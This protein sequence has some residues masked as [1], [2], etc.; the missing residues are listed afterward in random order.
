MNYIMIENLLFSIPMIILYAVLFGS[1]MKIADLLGEHGLKWFRG[2][3]LLFGILFGSFGALM[4]LSSNILAN[5]F[6]A[7]LIHWTLRFRIDSLEHGFAGAIMFTTFILNLNNFIFNPLIFWIILIP[8]SIFGLLNDLAD[9]KE[10]SGFIAKFV[11][12]EIHYLIIPLILL[13]IDIKYWI[14]LIVS[15][16]HA[17]SYGLVKYFFRKKGYH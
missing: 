1:T 3:A 5:F 15:L 14:I 8:F 17:I 16:G 13:I 2:G 7:M 4:I 10:I 12:S 9:K 11:K 6:I